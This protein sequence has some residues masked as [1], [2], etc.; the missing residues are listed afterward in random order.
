M[1]VFEE[2]WM[3][4]STHPSKSRYNPTSS[5]SSGSRE[6]GRKE[7]N[8]TSGQCRTSAWLIF[9]AEVGAKVEAKAYAWSQDW[10]A[11]KGIRNGNWPMGSQQRHFKIRAKD[12]VRTVS[13]QLPSSQQADMKVHVNTCWEP[14]MCLGVAGNQKWITCSPAS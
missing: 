1:E 10:A 9:R 13:G 5:R 4:T 7:E 8:G 14:T 12:V 2:N 11:E 6:E 3:V